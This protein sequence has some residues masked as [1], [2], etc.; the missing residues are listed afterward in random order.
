MSDV[1]SQVRRHL[2][3]LR[4]AGIDYIPPAP[5]LVIEDRTAGRRVALTT[6]AQE[7][8]GCQRC[9]E[10]FSTRTQT[11]FGVGPL[12]PDICFVG[13]APGADEDRQGEPFVGAAGQLLTLPLF[14][15]LGEGRQLRVAE[16]L[17]AALGRG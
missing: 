1:R 14:P 15:Q 7:V 16:A 2:E 5:P 11:V 17:A 8:A 12:S 10:L 9:P 6:L 4:A 13:E 3:A